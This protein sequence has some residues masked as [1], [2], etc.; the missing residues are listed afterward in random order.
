MSSSTALKRNTFRYPQTNHHHEI[1]LHKSS[2]SSITEDDH[3]DEV[4]ML[5]EP[6]FTETFKR[7]N[8]ITNNH[9]SKK[10]IGGGPMIQELLQSNMDLK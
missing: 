2:S 10:D 6:G 8:S 9:N 1:L 5:E 4:K 3:D 7:K